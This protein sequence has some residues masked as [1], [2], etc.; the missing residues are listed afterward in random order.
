MSLFSVEPVLA[1]TENDEED[2]RLLRAIANGDRDAFHRLHD[3]HGGLLFSTALKVLFEGWRASGVTDLR[4]HFADDPS[5]V[6]Q[7][8]GCIRV[9]KVNR[10]TLALYG[11]SADSSSLAINAFPWLWSPALPL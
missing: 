4:A 3:R 5:R 6:R 2:A 8:S 9:I 7:C 11:A 1:V 10:K